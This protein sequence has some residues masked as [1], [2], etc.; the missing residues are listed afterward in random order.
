MNL[1]IPEEFPISEKERQLI[2]KKILMFIGWCHSGLSCM[3]GQSCP[4][5]DICKDKGHVS[6]ED[7]INWIMEAEIS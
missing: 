4:F 3:A 5:M 7:I 2:K 1:L 6:H